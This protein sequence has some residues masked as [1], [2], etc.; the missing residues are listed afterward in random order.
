MSVFTTSRLKLEHVE[1]ADAPFILALLN[2][3][4]WLAYIGNSKVK[5]VADAENY[6]AEKLE[7]SYQTQGFGLFKMVLKSDGTAIGL[8]GLIK[9]D[10]LPELDIGFGMLPEYERKGYTYEAARGIVEYAFK[11]LGKNK[12]FGFTS[13]DNTASQR[14]LCKLGFIN[15]GVIKY[16]NTDEDVRLFGLLKKNY[17]VQLEGEVVSVSKSA[18]YS[19]SKQVFSEITLLK[20]LGIKG[21]IHAGKKVKHRSRVR[22]D[23]SQPNLRQVHL[24]HQELFEELKP[25]GFEVHPGEMG[26]NI[27]TKGIEILKLPQGTL[28]KIGE[29]AVIK[30]TGL[31]NPCAQL[32][33]LKD[34]LM[35]VLVFKDEAGNVIRK[36][37]IMS[38]V[39]VG[40][41]VRQGDRIKVELPAE[42]HL[43][44]EKV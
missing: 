9:R 43:P 21:D 34:G 30:I 4:G 35:N 3:D 39:E 24:M 22:R 44:L 6:I 18:I 41:I 2:T 1:Q 31:R 29:E 12:L 36:A 37:G 42:Q 38:V 13:L 17:V 26:E 32:N 20:G 14:L 28:L 33:G 11:Q 8:C 40:G 19:F 23:P 27:T 10:Y 5:T 25:K 15:E 16:G 7:K